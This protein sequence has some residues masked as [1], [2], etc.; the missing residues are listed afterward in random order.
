MPSDEQLDEARSLG[1]LL[2]TNEEIMEIMELDELDPKLIKAIR[3]GH[4]K[5]EADL[6]KSI[7]DLARSGSS[8]AQS[9]AKN[10]LDQLKR[11]NY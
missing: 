3:A 10:L 8:P 6:R 9:F 4:L 11:K 1:E 7:M 2:F 5:A